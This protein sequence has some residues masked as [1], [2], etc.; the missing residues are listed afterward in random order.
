MSRGAKRSTQKNT[1]KGP[2]YLE[3]LVEEESACEALRPLLQKLTESTRT[4]VG[5]RQF[6]GKPDLL[7]KLPARLKG[8]AASRRRGE[9]IRIVV[10]MDRDDDDCF[11][12]KKRLDRFAAEAGLISR[13][14]NQKSF[15][16]LNRI[17][18]RELEAW[19]FGDWA[20][21]RAGFPKAPA[22]IPRAYR[23]NPDAANGKCS[24]AFESSLRSEGIRIS[25]KPEWGRRIGPHLSLDGNKSPS[26]AA[27]VTG[28]REILN[29]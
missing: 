23:G 14:Q 1:N 27:F 16:V 19:Y 13:S 15:H 6:R 24:D 25:S 18:I 22:V 8:Y 10:L 20:A 7:K 9:D 12:L 17:A 4:K 3:V 21:V 11:S 29:S 26:F 28:V 5:I 2:I